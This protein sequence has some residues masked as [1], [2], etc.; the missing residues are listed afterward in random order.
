MPA[1][2]MSGVHFDGI[3]LAADVVVHRRVHRDELLDVAQ[4]L[5]ERDEDRHLQEKGQTPAER[6]DLV[7]LV[8]LHHLFVELLAV[9]LVL[10]LELLD[11]GLHPLHGDHRLRLLRGEREQHEPHRDREQDDRDTRVRDDGVEERED[12]AQALRG[13]SPRWP[14]R[15]CRR[16][17]QVPNVCSAPWMRGVGATLDIRRAAGTGSKPP[18]CHGW[19]RPIRRMPIQTPRPRPWSS[20]ASRV[21]SEQ[22]GAKR[23]RGVEPAI[24]TW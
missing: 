21:Y 18:A 22:V 10:R 14:R 7:L 13:W 8:E 20:I 1:K 4:R 6:V 16:S 5:E 23:Q 19:H 3:G 24:T 12:R 9:V 2:C 17:F 15:S 11:L